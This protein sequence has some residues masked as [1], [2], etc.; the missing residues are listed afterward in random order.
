LASG[1][2]QHAID[3]VRIAFKS[4]VLREAAVGLSQ[5]YV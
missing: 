2:E 3:S 1:S 4:E 5:R